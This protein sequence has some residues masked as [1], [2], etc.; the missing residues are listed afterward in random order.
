MLNRRIADLIRQMHEEYPDMGYRRLRDKLEHDYSID[1]NDKRILRVC[2]RLKIQSMIRNPHNCCTRPSIDPAYIADNV[3][4]RDFSADRPD[5]KWVTD[6][7]EFKYGADS[8]HP[9]KLY[10]SAVLDLYGRIPVSYVIS[11]HNDN[12]LVFDTYDRAHAKRPWASP[13]FHSDRGFQYTSKGFHDRLE[14]AR[15]VQSMSRVGHCTDNGVMEGFWGILKREF[16]YGKK[17]RTR[18][19]LVNAIVKYLDYYTYRRPQRK[20][21]VKTPEEYVEDYE[22]AV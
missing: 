21:G 1:V 4:N 12:R 18:E 22:R 14:K 11:D 3:L 6:V 2:R 16:Y 17:F 10:L 19:E 9:H 15:M 8:D 20:L 13:L 5:Q 7:S